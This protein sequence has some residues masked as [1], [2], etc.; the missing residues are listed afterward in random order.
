[1]WHFCILKDRS[2]L[3]EKHLCVWLASELNKLL[4]GTPILLGKNDKLIIQMA[5]KHVVTISPNTAVIKKKKKLL[6]VFVSSD[7]YLKF[8]SAN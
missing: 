6:I 8:L 1:M 5:N 3:E 4:D 2:C 7:K